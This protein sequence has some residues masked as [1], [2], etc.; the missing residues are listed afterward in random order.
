MGRTELFA[1]SKGALGEGAFGEL[2]EQLTTLRQ[3]KD[4]MR[5]LKQAVEETTLTCKQVIAFFNTMKFG[6]SKPQAVILCYPG[7]S[8]RD[9]FEQVLKALPFEEDRKDV[10][11]A[12]KL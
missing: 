3:D 11:A 6:E 12:L 1:L 9:N 4:R 5:L 10:K 2:L 7:I 8:D